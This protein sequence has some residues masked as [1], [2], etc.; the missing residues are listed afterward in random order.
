MISNYCIHSNEGILPQM[1]N[2]W[3]RQ[4]ILAVLL[5]LWYDI[6]K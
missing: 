6:E 4:L 2:Y 5:K 1:F 3:Q